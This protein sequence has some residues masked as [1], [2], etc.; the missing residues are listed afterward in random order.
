MKKVFDKVQNFLVE[1]NINEDK[2]KVAMLLSFG[3]DHIR[4][5]VDNVVPKVEGY[6]ATVQYLNN[7]LHPKTNDTFE[8]YKFQKIIQDS[9]ETVHFVITLD[10]SLTDGIWRIRINT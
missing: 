6:N 7:H 4:D 10:L 2:R 8:I 1:I 9:D 3:G 5:I